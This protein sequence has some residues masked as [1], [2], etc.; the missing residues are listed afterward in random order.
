MRN[1][2]CLWTQ[3]DTNPEEVVS[4]GGIYNQEMAQSMELTNK[5]D[6]RGVSTTR[7]ELVNK[8][9]KVATPRRRQG[10]SGSCFRCGQKHTPSECWC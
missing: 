4:R 8:V 1:A 3:K 9:D 10:E 6:I 5:K 7:D 2:Y